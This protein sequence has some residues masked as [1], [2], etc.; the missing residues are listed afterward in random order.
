MLARRRFISLAVASTLAPAL[1]RRANAQAYPN[2][3]VRLV[4]PFPPGGGTDPIARVLSN[5][6]SDMWGQQVVI[7]NRG[8][9]GGNLGAQAVAQAAPDGYTILFVAPFLAT[10]PFFYTSI[11]YDSVAD[12]AS[13]TL[14]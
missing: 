13:V 1:T 2:R 14:I 7:E 8:G 9:A 12:F 6:L 11:G 5:R 4:V 10:N 3:F